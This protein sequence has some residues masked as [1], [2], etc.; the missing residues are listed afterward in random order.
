[1][2]KMRKG[3]FNLLSSFASKILLINGQKIAIV[4]G[5]RFNIKLTYPEDMIIA[6]ALL[7]SGIV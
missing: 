6:G 3:V 2:N 1:M 4:N 7:E 5:E